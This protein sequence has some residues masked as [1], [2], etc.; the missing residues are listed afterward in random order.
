MGLVGDGAGTR[1]WAVESLNNDS[2]RFPHSYKNTPLGAGLCCPHRGECEAR[3][4]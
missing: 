1:P 3:A 4:F 2:S